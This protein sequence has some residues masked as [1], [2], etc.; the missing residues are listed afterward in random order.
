MSPMKETL[1]DRNTFVTEVQP[2]NAPSSSRVTQTLS[3]CLTALGKPMHSAV[4]MLLAM[5]IKTAVSVWLLQI[6][7]VGIYGAVAAA[8]VGYATSFLFDLFF[9][10]HA[11]R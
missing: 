4:S 1:S 11:T 2:K 8:S 10:L 5:L 9:A 3:A 7:A 6:P